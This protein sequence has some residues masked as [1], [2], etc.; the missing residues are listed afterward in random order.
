M[1]PLVA[2]SVAV[3]VPLVVIAFNV[4]RLKRWIKKLWSKTFGGWIESLWLR[5]FVDKIR[6]V[7]IAL[8]KKSSRENSSTIKYTALVFWGV[9][10]EFWES[11]VER[12]RRLR[13]CVSEL[14]PLDE[15]RWQ[16]KFLWW[17]WRRARR[18]SSED[19]SISIPSETTSVEDSSSSRSRSIYV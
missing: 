11:G 1:I 16:F 14:E 6:V 10:G 7:K 3:S 9:A 4:N 18:G 19:E 2:I 5:F 15:S 12:L 17:K 8:S 13:R